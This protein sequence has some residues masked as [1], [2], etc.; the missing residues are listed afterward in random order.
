MVLFSY[1]SAVSS[2]HSMRGE[3][4][5]ATN[6]WSAKHFRKRV[7]DILPVQ[8]W[9]TCKLLLPVGSEPIYFTL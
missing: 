4:I 8:D 5:R 7:H 3:I 9:E 2:V 6:L 1:V